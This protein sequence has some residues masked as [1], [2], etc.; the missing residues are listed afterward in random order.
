M[1]VQE[2][3]VLLGKK[4]TYLLDHLALPSKDVVDRGFF[5]SDR[6]ICVLQNLQ[7]F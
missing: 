6:N 7:S 2:L 5:N 4:L 3:E 1:L